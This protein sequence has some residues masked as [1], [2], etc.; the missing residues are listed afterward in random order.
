M[1]KHNIF[2]FFR[3]IKKHK[4]S[5]LINIIG[6]STGLASVLLI[7][8]WVL[9]E[10]SIDKFHKNDNQL[11]QVMNNFENPDGIQT[12]T[13][14]PT[15]LAEELIEDMPEVVSSLTILNPSMSP[16][17]VVSIENHYIDIKG[18]FTSK[19]FFEV[20]SYK[21]I[22][23]DKIKV[24]EDKNSIV[25]SKKL[26]IKMFQ[27][28]EHII[29]KNVKWTNRFFDTTFQITGIFE[30]P[31]PNSTLQFDAVVD[32]DW[33]V[34]ND[35]DI[36]AWSDA[37]AETFLV[38]KENTKIDNF[39]S[40]IRNYLHS[41]S[42]WWDSSNL[43]VQQYSQKYLYGRYE[44]GK[45]T[46]GRIEYVK[47]FSLI[48]VFIL[49]IACINFIN[50]S[51]AYAFGK[52]KEIAVKKTIGVSKNVL[53]IQFLSESILMVILSLIIALGLVSFLLP[54]FNLITGKSLL[55]QFS[56][57]G[58]ISIIGFVL[59]TGLMAGSYPA[60]YLSRFNPSA[61]KGSF[62]HTLSNISLRKALVIFQFS[63]SVIFITFVL[64]INK[65]MEYIQNKNLGYNRDN[66]VSFQRKGNLDSLDIFISEIKKIPGVSNASSMAGSSFI[67]GSSSQMGYSWRGQKSDE[68][69]VFKSPQIGY[70]AIETLQMT[71]ISGRSFL[72][73]YYDDRTK[74][75]INET[76]LQLMQLKDPIGKII[77]KD[78]GNAIEKREIIGVVKD[79]N[80]GSIHENIE[81]LILRF[82][83]QGRNIIVKIKGGA[84]IASLEQI[85]KLYN[86][87]HPKR[88]FD[89]SFLDDD[90]QVLYESETRV[91][92]LSKYFAGLAIIIS[93]LGLFGLATFD[94]ERR[95]KEIGIRKVLGQSTSQITIMLS[96]EFIKLVLI[97]IVVALPIA[98][99]LTN[100][101]LE[102]FAYRIKI[103]WWVFVLVGIAALVIALIT[104]SFQSIKVA[105]AN[106]VKSLR[107][108]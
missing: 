21:L 17:G 98:Y 50:L 9:D 64:V 103:E 56:L 39:N 82:R 49:L 96:I 6:L 44:N 3:N 31:P 78:V 10:M 38:L 36:M 100:N 22:E 43:F 62:N 73:E 102:N 69:I 29:G 2:L 86:E 105:L 108:E 45:Q 97:S 70:G 11:Y 88:D 14:T 84:E 72:K 41:K 80:Y 4:S 40:K 90:Y 61:L 25:I 27:T 94:S 71:I 33:I 79:F 58:V 104:I 1:F 24:L 46:G 107:I 77:N 101:W 55:I 57:K 34:K 65:Q 8:L 60:F 76:A 59:L 18:I 7:S 81:P 30:N 99:L 47:L 75:I 85:K 13:T 66:I 12:W 23:G 74:I 106:P 48:A 83:P 28:T 32:Y 54:Q 89:F 51:T 37:Y 92:V 53:F 20:L 16:E 91:A 68:E 26:A 5:F 67:K 93:F 95:R 35:Q 15:L 52:I 63:I 19:N 87:F 42:V